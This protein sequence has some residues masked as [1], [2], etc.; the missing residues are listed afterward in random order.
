MTPRQRHGGL[1]EEVLAQRSA[2]KARCLKDRAINQHQADISATEVTRLAQHGDVLLLA[3]GGLGFVLYL[4]AEGP[5]LLHLVVFYYIV[6]HTIFWAEI[7]DRVYLMPYIIVFAAYAVQVV[8][9]RWLRTYP[10][11][12]ARRQQMIAQANV[13]SAV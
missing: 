10:K 9:V 2:L 4:R 7:R 11:T 5:G 12:P 3:L 13:R 1:H 6:V 8:G